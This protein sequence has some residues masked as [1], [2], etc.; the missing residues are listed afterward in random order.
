MYYYENTVLINSKIHLSNFP[1]LLTIYI[2]GI[3]NTCY[4][5]VNF[6][7]LLLNWIICAVCKGRMRHFLVSYLLLPLI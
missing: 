7:V 1:I 2:F 6:V 5:P 3:I 4:K